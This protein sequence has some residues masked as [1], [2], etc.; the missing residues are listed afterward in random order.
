MTPRIAKAAKKMRDLSEQ[1]LVL[2]EVYE[3]CDDT[4]LLMDAALNEVRPAD[5]VL[6]V[7]TGC[8]VIAKRLAERAR[9]VIATDK[10]PRAVENARLNGVEAIMGDLFADLD[11]RFDLII[12]NPPY[13]PSRGDVSRDWQN[14]AWDGGPSGREVI[15]QFL[16]QVGNYL[17]QKGRVLLVISSVTGYEE[18]TELM[19]AQFGIV[20]AIAERK[21]FFEKLYV[22]LGAE[23]TRSGGNKRRSRV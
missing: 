21:F 22:V 7:G 2:S 11:S 14:Q 18:V 9:C 10:N 23:A 6:E 12:F 16:S 17:T 4:Y 15:V 13:L 20:K 5:S 8:G 3:P 1:V 19:H